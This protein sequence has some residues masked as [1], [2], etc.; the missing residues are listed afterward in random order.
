MVER[1][2][3]LPA[4]V[5]FSSFFFSTERFKSIV[6]LKS[7]V[8]S[9]G[10]ELHAIPNPNLSSLWHQKNI[11][12]ESYGLLLWWFLEFDR[13]RAAWTFFKVGMKLKYDIIKCI[14]IMLL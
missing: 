11:A 4:S 14:L 5:F 7:N 8:L 9:S 1:L 10:T 13:K 6:K 12:H 2:K 3:T